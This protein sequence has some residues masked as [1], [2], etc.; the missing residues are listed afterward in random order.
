[1][2]VRHQ[3]ELNDNS[4]FAK[5]SVDFGWTFLVPKA[6]RVDQPEEVVPLG[7]ENKR[8]SSS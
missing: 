8:M 4:Y 3:S 1:M 2:A 7:P 6:N 5:G